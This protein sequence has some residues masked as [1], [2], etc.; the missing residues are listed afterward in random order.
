MFPSNEHQ[1]S[2]PT[3]SLLLGP[4]KEQN[5]NVDLSRTP[6]LNIESFMLCKIVTL[7]Y[8]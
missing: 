6:I 8:Y 5:E 1:N 7:K 3:C 4:F 2:L